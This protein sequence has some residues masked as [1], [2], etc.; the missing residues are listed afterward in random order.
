MLS[1]IILVIDAEDFEKLMFS[2]E[3]LQ[4]LY[5]Q[6]EQHCASNG[7]SLHSSSPLL[8]YLNKCDLQGAMTV[9]Q[10]LDEFKVLELVKQFKIEKYHIQPCCALNNTGVQEG[11]EWLK[12]NL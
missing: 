3:E 9:T 7:T 8:I 12:T 2:F 6:W 1:G 10:F 4:V 11:L 5:K